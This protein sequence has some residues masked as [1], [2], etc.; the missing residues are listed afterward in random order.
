MDETNGTPTT[1]PVRDQAYYRTITAIPTF[2]PWLMPGDLQDYHA[3]LSDWTELSIEQFYYIDKAVRQCRTL[4]GELW[5]CGSYR[6]GSG[7]FIAAVAGESRRVR[8]F[9]TFNGLPTAQVEFDLVTSSYADS[10][11]DIALSALA[12]VRAKAELHPGTIPASFRGLEHTPLAFVHC[13]LSLYRSTRECL[14]FCY[15]RIVKNG[16]IL[17]EGYALPE[18]A[19]VRAAVDEFFTDK[20]ELPLALLGGAAMIIKL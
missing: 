6:G 3:R 19:G 17:I 10:S 14:E 1:L 8:L 9:D 18:T 5:D 16:I 4:E 11:V 7:A 12:A 20:R 15:P 13:D 2:K